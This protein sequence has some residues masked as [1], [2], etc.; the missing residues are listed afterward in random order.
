MLEVRQLS[1]VFFEENDSRKPGL[2]A[3]YN[4]SLAIRKNEFVSLLGPSGCGK[5]TLIRIIAGLLPADCGEVLVNG[6][7]V[8][9]PGRDRC[10]VFQQFGLLPWRTVLSNVEFGLEIEG[11]PKDERSALA[12]QY[13]E[14][15]GLKGFEHYYPHQ[16]SGGMQQRVGIARA[17]SKK[18]D[19]LLMD[20]PFGAVDAQTR[21]QLQEELLKIWSRT[22]TTVVFVTHSIDE[23]L[24][25][26]DRVVVMQARPGRI[27]EEVSVDLPRPRW[28]G[29]VKADPRFA[30]LRSQ[31]R[32]S[33]R[34]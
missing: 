33:L 1:K 5:T 9:V 10:M 21:E 23:A 7:A 17:L 30:Q 18:P 6:Q 28:E 4:I 25:L 12:G 24:Y 29:D 14:L 32:E 31:L 15:V 3:L 26:S 19:I 8:T 22:D 11:V 16:I 27:K 13:L 2:V 34:G 20:E